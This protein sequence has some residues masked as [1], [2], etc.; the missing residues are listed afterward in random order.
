MILQ[1]YKNKLF[2]LFIVN[3]IADLKFIIVILFFVNAF[4]TSLFAQE[5]PQ[6]N[7]DDV[8]VTASRTPVA[9]SN[10]TRS[11]I[12]I[13][14]VQIKELPVN[15]VQSLLQYAAGVS[16]EQRGVDGV[17]SDLNIRGGTTEETLIMLDGVALNDPQT[18]HHNLNLP[19]SLNDIERIE[20]L[21]GPGSSLYGANAFSG[22]INIITKKGAD[23]ALSLLAEGGQNNYFKSSFYGA[24]PIG[25]WNSHFSVSK[26][27]SDG[28][29]YN[30]NFDISNFSY[31]ASINSGIGI[32]NLFFGYI[33]KKFGANGFYGVAY[34]NQWEHTTTKLVS[35][36]GDYGNSSFS[37]L[38]KI[39]WRRN[40][41][42]YLLDYIHPSY[43]QNIHQTNLYGSEL[44]A[45]I[46]NSFGITSIGGEF[47]NDEIKS[48]NLGI[49]SRNRA[50]FFA[51]QKL[52]FVNKLTLVA[53]LFAYNY[54]GIGWKFWPGIDVGY[55]ISNN[56]HTYGTIGKAFRI[57]TYTELF[58]K[59]PISV[60]NPN[61]KFEETI[62]YE[63]GANL[64]EKFYNAKISLFHKQGTNLID[65]VRQYNSQPWMAMNISRLNTDGIEISYSFQTNKIISD[66][67]IENINLSYTY[68]NSNKKPMSFQSQYLLEYLRNQLIL[69]VDN[70]C[71]FGIKQNWELRYEDRVNFEDYLLIDSKLY[72][73]LAGFQ[74]FLEVTN[75]FNKSYYEISGVPLPGRWISSGIEYS[76]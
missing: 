15:D 39:Y 54:S 23:R 40:D 59:S 21:K 25:I 2:H 53:N 58:Y 20:I 52:S 44:Q 45:S 43:Y 50:G 42:N 64:N 12:V 18:G 57:P 71:W 37:I 76:L 60:G 36:L 72:K 16:L 73:N 68:L 17:Q 55:N 29:R 1:V 61:L 51:E 38:P 6:Y 65:W 8:I 3:D 22:V 33:D 31:G 34:P 5:V 69:S 24:Y 74:I 32:T 70:T 48:S 63:I 67:P 26:E 19:V 66:F 11:V 62:D 13:D 30:T 47:V 27:K 41:D 28:Y 56:F 49:H 46:K 14:S 10:L 4:S 75:L 9:F 7:L 35:F